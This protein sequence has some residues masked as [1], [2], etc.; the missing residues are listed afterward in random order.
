MT[1]KWQY[2]STEIS[3]DAT[4]DV[5]LNDFSEDQLLQGL[6]D[7]GWLREEEAEIIRQRAENPKTSGP[8]AILFANPFDA[9]E[10]EVAT[11]ELLGGRKGEALIRLERLLGHAWAGVLAQ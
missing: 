7:S 1:G 3:T 9:D 4:V 11:S 10:L 2:Q 8:R 5:D 6:I